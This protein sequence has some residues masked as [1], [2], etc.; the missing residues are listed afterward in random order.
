MP[1]DIPTDG[2][3]GDAWCAY[4]WA[5]KAGYAPCHA[6]IMAVH[7]AVFVGGIPNSW[8]AATMAQDAYEET[9]P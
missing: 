2:Q 8:E 5:R 4:C 7:A 1:N 9:V 3:I 6:H